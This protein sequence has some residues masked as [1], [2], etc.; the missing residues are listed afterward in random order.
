M[1]KWCLPT[2]ADA[3]FVAAM[4]DVLGVYARPL[5]PHRPLVCF[6]ESGKELQDHA[7]PALPAQPGHV[8][9]EDSQYVR[10]G[11]ANLFLWCAPLLGRRGITVTRQRTRIDWAHAMRTLVDQDFPAAEKIVLVLDNLNTH[12]PAALYATFPPAEAKRIWDRLEL[13]FTPKHGSWLNKAEIEFSALM[14]QCLDRRIPDQVTLQQ[15]VTAWTTARNAAKRTIDWQFTTTD[16]RTKL[17]RL[18]P[19]LAP[20]TSA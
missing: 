16:A 9:R 8:A 6:D 1:R 7:R 10:G 17:H 15:A 19:S 3:A 18:Y 2:E 11:S 20:D 4:E 12:T 14:R 13:H 5:D